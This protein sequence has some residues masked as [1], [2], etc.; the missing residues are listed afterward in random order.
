MQ[1]NQQLDL[2]FCQEHEWEFAIGK[3]WPGFLKSGINT[4]WYY[5]GIV[6]DYIYY[7]VWQCSKCKKQKPATYQDVL[8][9]KDKIHT[10][11]VERIDFDKIL[12]PDWFGYYWI[13][14]E[15]IRE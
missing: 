6:F 10:G 2:D 11:Y 8:D 12:E 4:T 1:D 14:D 15:R 5:P 9:N 3:V 13:I 7:F